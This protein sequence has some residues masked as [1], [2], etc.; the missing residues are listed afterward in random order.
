MWNR[1]SDWT[2]IVASILITPAVA[3]LGADDETAV[4]THK[5]HLTLRA[6]V[7]LNIDARFSGT[8]SFKPARSAGGT[9]SALDHYY[10]DG[11]VRVDSSGNVGGKTWFWGYDAASQISGD[12]ILFHSTSSTSATSP[13]DISDNPQLGFELVYNRE[14]GTFGKR[15]QHRWGLEASIGWTGIGINDNSAGRANVTR[16]TD[17]YGFTTGTIP[18][19]APFQGT[20]SGANFLLGDTPSRTIQSIS[21]AQVTGSREFD[22][23]LFIGHLGPYADF[24]LSEKLHLSVSGGLAIGGM[25]SE[26]SWD[27][28]VSFSG[29]P[30]LRHHASDNDSGFLVGGFIGANLGYQFNPRWNA[31]LGVQF[32]SLGDYSQTVAGH[33]ASI[34]LGKSLYVTVGIGYSF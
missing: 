2:W 15:K 25:F 22:G 10:D 12:N 20:F 1:P 24:A 31:Q 34:D 32:E 21:G 3:S 14:I 27:E 19:A 23:N 26:F 29:S 28:T 11:Y 4:G 18:P 17:A 13:Q 7:G 9:G 8:G 6:R 5:D 30:P 33:K 16:V